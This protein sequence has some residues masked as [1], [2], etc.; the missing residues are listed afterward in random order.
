M[1]DEFVERFWDRRHEILRMV[2]YCGG[3]E[4]FKGIV[5]GEVDA[6]RVAG[7]LVDE[8]RRLGRSSKTINYYLFWFKRLLTF[9]GV[10]YDPRRIRIVANPPPVRVAS[11]DRAPTIQELRRIL[12]AA[13]PNLR[14]TL[15][16]LAATG[17]RIGE[18]LSLRWSDL[19]LDHD[20]PIARV[21]S[22]K[23]GS[24]REVPLTREILEM[25]ESRRGAD[26]ILPY[27]SISG[28]ENAFHRLMRRIGLRKPAGANRYDLR[29]HSLRKFYKT[30]LEE[31]G[32]NPLVIELWM[33]HATGVIHAYFKPSLRM[34]REEW[35]KAEPALTIFAEQE[36][37]G[38][39]EEISR[40][41]E[42]EREISELRR[43]VSRLLARRES[44][45]NRLDA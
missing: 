39:E 4:V 15:H 38:F 31:A 35:R 27:S 17:L 3:V 1:I 11:C 33:G 34:I 5:R 6:A 21:R 8:L 13:N 29:I 36:K 23:T 42:L 37:I 9:L 16:F 20:P 25:L 10:S 41:E 43:I 12:L 7:R 28:V 26:K 40:I 45:H 14:F 44:S 22:A 2:E 18:A 24:I 19:D 32:V 30:R